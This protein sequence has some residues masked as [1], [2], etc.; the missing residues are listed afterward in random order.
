MKLG[1]HD[2]IVG[3]WAEAPSGPG[4]SNRLLT[5]CIRNALDGRHR[6]EAF[7]PDEQ[8]AQFQYAFSVLVA[9]SGVMMAEAVAACSRQPKKRRVK[10]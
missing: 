10:P 1:E 3:A 7:Q 6:V 8:T 2:H 5:V 9:A 4:W